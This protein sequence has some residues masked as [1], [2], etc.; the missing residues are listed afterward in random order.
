MRGG[1]YAAFSKFG[2][3]VVEGAVVGGEDCEGAG[4]ETEPD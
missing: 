1:E 4:A 2:V 3:G